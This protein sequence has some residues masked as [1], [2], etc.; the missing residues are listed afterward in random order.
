MTD[1]KSAG[2]SAL[3]LI[4][5]VCVGDLSLVCIL[6][7]FIHMLLWILCNYRNFIL[8]GLTRT[9]SSYRFL[10]H[11]G[12]VHATTIFFYINMINFVCHCSKNHESFI[13]LFVRMILT[14]VFLSYQS[15][16]DCTVRD[17]NDC[18]L[19]ISLSPLICQC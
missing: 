5:D 4:V 9:R 3:K 10:K 8:E 14:V 6:Y 1:G 17:I 7:T 2:R 15:Y 16:E 12:S 11:T 19:M 13:L 18:V